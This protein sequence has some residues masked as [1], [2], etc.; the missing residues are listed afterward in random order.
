[1]TIAV[2][3][4]GSQG[5]TSSA[6]GLGCMGMTFGYKDKDWDQAEGARVINAA[7]QA[8]VTHLDTSDIYGPHTN[9]VL[10]GKAIKGQR[11]KFMLA[12][13][14]GNLMKDGQ[15]QQRGDPAYVKEAIQG[16]LE[17][18][19]VDNVDL[20]YLH[21]VDRKT[22]IEDTVKAMAELVKEGKVKYLGLSE[23]SPAEV[24]AAH[25]VHPISAVQLEWSLWTRD[26]EEELIPT[27]RELGIGIV[28]YSPLG[29]GM[30]TGAIQSPDDFEEGDSRKSHPRFQGENFKKN[31][32]LVEKVKAI[33]ERKG[34]TPGQLALAWV[35]AQGDDVFPIPGTKRE[36]Y[37]AENV[38]A[39]DVSR[40]L[41]K[42][43]LAEIEAAFPHTEVVGERYGEAHMKATYRHG[44]K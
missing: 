35:H 33:A 34:C 25:A 19:G 8:G 10:V 36:K 24:R 13:K 41:S 43:D 18:L 30:L 38:K 28:A 17:R 42:E 39:F 15:M 14:F 12:T 11:E 7:L 27:C 3:P 9:E 44:K 32:K 29:R 6:Q 23:A 5:L 20:Y 16:S 1:M 31:M 4:L 22:P 2:R 26:A 40:Q 37:L 21:R